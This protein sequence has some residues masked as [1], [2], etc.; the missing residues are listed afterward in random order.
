MDI[1]KVYLNSSKCTLL[2]CYSPI[3]SLWF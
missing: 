2:L 3:I 1:Q